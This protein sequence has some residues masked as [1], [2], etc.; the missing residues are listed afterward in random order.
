MSDSSP[1][2]F[3]TPEAEEAAR[4]I[5]RKTLAAQLGGVITSPHGDCGPF[6]T[7]LVN[8]AP[9]V[10]PEAVP[11]LILPLLSNLRG[12]LSEPTYRAVSRVLAGIMKYTILQQVLPG[13]GA[14]NAANID[15]LGTDECPCL[16]CS[17]R[18]AEA[19]KHGLDPSTVRH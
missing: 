2:R 4:E 7:K 6:L 19:Q 16:V 1:P 12:E 11:S 13:F 8:S 3:S 17:I 9:L 14:V 10:A 15:K 5:L 18:R